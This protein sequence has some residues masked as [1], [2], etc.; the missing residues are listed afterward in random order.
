MAHN[1]TALG[2]SAARRSGTPSQA[3]RIGSDTCC[4]AAPTERARAARSA[5]TNRSCSASRL[6]TLTRSRPCDTRIP[7]WSALEYI[8][9]LH[10]LHTRTH[11]SL[12]VPHVPMHA[13]NALQ[14]C[15]R[16]RTHAA[17]RVYRTQMRPRVGLRARE[18]IPSRVLSW[19]RYV[20]SCVRRSRQVSFGILLFEMAMGYSIGCAFPLGQRVSLPS[21]RVP[22]LCT[23]AYPGAPLPPC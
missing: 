15:R 22:P 5:T 7:T 12:C 23:L 13:P 20:R 9:S 11:A 14:H 18:L 17:K 21:R 8:S 16:A 10:S 6:S 3:R 2:R 19:S 1:S 4:L